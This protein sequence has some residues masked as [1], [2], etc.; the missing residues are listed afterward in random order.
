[1]YLFKISYMENEL[2][3]IYFRLL[4]PFLGAILGHWDYTNL[5][6]YFLVDNIYEGIFFWLKA[7][8]SLSDDHIYLLPSSNKEPQT[9]KSVALNLAF[10]GF[11][12]LATLIGFWSL[13]SPFHFRIGFGKPLLIILLMPLI[14][15]SY[16][17]WQYI[18]QKLFTLITWGM[19]GHRILI[20]ILITAFLCGAVGFFAPQYASPYSQIA[21]GSSVTIISFIVEKSEYKKKKKEYKKDMKRELKK[22]KEDEEKK[23][24]QEISHETSVKKDETSL[25]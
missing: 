15:K 25:T 5:A 9:G 2:I 21:L 14:Q 3:G 19:L 18:N 11:L 17:F 24:Q 1:M 6:F 10:I 20:R 16:D 12:L 4:V 13:Y 23:L 8:Y 7:P 22:E